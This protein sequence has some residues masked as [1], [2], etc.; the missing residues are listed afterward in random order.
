MVEGVE[1]LSLLVWEKLIWHTHLQLKSMPHRCACRCISVGAC[2]WACT[3]EA[4]WAHLVHKAGCIDAPAIAHAYGPAQMNPAVL[5]CCM[6]AGYVGSPAGVPADGPAQMDPGG[7][8]CCM[9]CR[10]HR[11]ACRSTSI[12]ACTCTCTDEASWAHRVHGAGCIDSPAAA[13]AQMKPARHTFCMEAGCID[14]PADAC[15]HACRRACT[16]EFS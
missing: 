10:L 14:A 2:K 7:H 5:T 4:S 3:D 13:P 9:D 1:K 16:D 11:Y 12:C 15:T 6:E 8:T